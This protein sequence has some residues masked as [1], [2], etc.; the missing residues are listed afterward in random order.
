MA[1]YRQVSA[2]LNFRNPQKSARLSKMSQTHLKNYPKIDQLA[3]YRQVSAK[4]NFRNPQKSAR[5]SKMSQTHLKN[6]PK[7]DQLTS[8][9]QVSAKLIM[10]NMEC[11]SC[12][13]AQFGDPMAL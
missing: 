13:L 11:I 1:S 12:I 7:I 6:Y 5:L 3:S 8:Y 10:P 4:L 2:K 9:R